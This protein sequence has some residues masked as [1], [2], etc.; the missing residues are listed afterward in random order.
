MHNLVLQQE[1]D[2]VLNLAHAK[3]KLVCT[4]GKPQREIPNAKVSNHL[5]EK[6]IA[7]N[8]Q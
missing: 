5:Y 6:T 8:T 4:V 3:G 7:G 2:F 1:T